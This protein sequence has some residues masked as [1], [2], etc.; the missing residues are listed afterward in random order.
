MVYYSIECRYKMIGTI[1]I[2]E[3]LNPSLLLTN[4]NIQSY[5]LIKLFVFNAR[6]MFTRYSRAAPFL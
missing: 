1:F 6:E 4:Y 3:P 5:S 2:K